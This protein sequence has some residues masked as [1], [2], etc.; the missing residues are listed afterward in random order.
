MDQAVKY[1]EDIQDDFDF[2]YKTLQSRGVPCEKKPFLTTVQKTAPPA[3]HNIMLKPVCVCVSESTDPRTNSET[4]K[5]EVTRLQEMLN[6]L[7]F[8]RKVSTGVIL[9]SSDTGGM[10]PPNQKQRDKDASHKPH[11]CTN[12]DLLTL[13]FLFFLCI[14][15]DRRSCQRWML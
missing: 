7:D 13:T 10:S 8:K 6:R 9:Q 15:F 4:M 5:Q 1:I 12:T 3:T 11:R 14:S 2:R